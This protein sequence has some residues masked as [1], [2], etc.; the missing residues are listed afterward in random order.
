MG[1]GVNPGGA[2]PAEVETFQNWDCVNFGH[3]WP[4]WAEFWPMSAKSDQFR[5]KLVGVF[6][7]RLQVVW[8]ELD[9]CSPD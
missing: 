7:R 1:A 3:V 4:T 5:P 6:R 8:S 2:A 9:K